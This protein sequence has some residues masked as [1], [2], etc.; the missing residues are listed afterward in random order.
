M[1]LSTNHYCGY[2]ECGEDIRMTV[3]VE[4]VYLDD[5]CIQEYTEIDLA[6]YFP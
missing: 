6:Q 5:N 1:L 3:Y 2:P 4:P